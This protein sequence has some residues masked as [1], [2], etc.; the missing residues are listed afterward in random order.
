MRRLADL[1]IGIA[2]RP[3]QDRPGEI[4]VAAVQHADGGEA[5]DRVGISASRSGPAR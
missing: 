2:A 5:L 4:A 3:F 1:R